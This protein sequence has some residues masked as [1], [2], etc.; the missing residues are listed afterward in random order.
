MTSPRALPLSAVLTALALTLT[1]CG[2]GDGSDA[3]DVDEEALNL[4]ILYPQTGSLAY[5]G[6]PQ[7]SATEYAIEEINAA[8]GVLGTDMPAPI[9]GDEA[10]DEGRAN[11]AANTLIADGSDAV[12]GAASSGMTQAVHDTVTGAGIPQCSG[13][14][15]A[16]D[17]TDIDDG[18]NFYRTAPSD[19]LAAPVLA[20]EILDDGHQNVAII[21]R[22]DDYGSGYLQ[23][24]QNELRS[25]GVQV[26]VSESY[27]PDTT[28]FGSVVE[29]VDE[30]D[31]DAVSLISFEEG[32]QILAALLEAGIDGDQLY[33]TDGLNDP[34]LG[35]TVSDNTDLVNGVTGVA[36]SADNPEFSQGISDFD[37]DLE[38]FQFAPQVFDCVNLVA[39]AAESA[40][41]TDP[42]EYATHVDEVSRPEGTECGSFEECRDLLDDGQDIDYQGASGNI[43]LDDNGDPTSATF[44]V[45]EFGSG[46]Y[47]IREYVEY[48][49]EEN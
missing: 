3:P 41:S 32:S 26:P 5:L 17:L 39:L 35:S 34:N 13:S 45:F 25:N 37:S 7:L 24:V 31:I 19:L 33:V 21:A 48:S 46:G 20:Q 11:D 22:A 4:G 2:N 47:D 40:S 6:P 12:I 1:A 29:S 23:A 16:P 30:R 9:Q 43:D 44:E 8:G 27:D 38:V 42:A 10:D 15:T 28:N 36:P 18:G 49:D 14:A